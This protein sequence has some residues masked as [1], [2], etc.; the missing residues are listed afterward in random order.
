M[1]IWKQAAVSLVVL[2]VAVALWARTFPTAAA[3]LE[4]AGIATASVEQDRVAGSAEARPRIGRAAGAGR[5][6][7]GGD[8]GDDQRQRFRH[9]RRPRRALG[10]RDALCRR[11]RVANRGRGGRLCH[12]GDP[13]R[14]ARLRDRG[15][16]PRPRAPQP[17]RRARHADPRAGA[18][19]LRSHHR[20]PAP[21]RAARREPGRTRLARRRT[22]ARAPCG[23]GVLRRM[24]RDP[25]RWTWATRSL[26]RRG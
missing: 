13:A 9:R 6:R 18:R 24:G 1:R 17:R 26:P 12:G 8:A 20:D 11:A 3:F 2:V 22:G 5:R 23:P 19:S 15:D 7:R 21:R 4:R 14:Q 10:Q 25:R 16:R